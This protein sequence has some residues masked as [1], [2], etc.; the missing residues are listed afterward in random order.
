VGGVLGRRTRAVQARVARLRSLLGA[1]TLRTKQVLRN[2][3]EAESLLPE[4]V[5]LRDL[6]A[7]DSLLPSQVVQIGIAR[8]L[9]PAGERRGDD[10][11]DDTTRWRWDW[12]EQGT[13]GRADAAA[14]TAA[15]HSIMR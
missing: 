8:A 5:L 15:V 9:G 3:G 10:D 7:A 1:G 13:V 4:Q 6:G 2:V 12:C 14:A 11:D